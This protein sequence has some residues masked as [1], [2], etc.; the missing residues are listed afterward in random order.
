MSKNPGVLWPIEPHTVAKLDILRFYLDA[1]FPILSARAP[2]LLYIDG[3]AGPGRYL[4]G[5][6]GSPIVALNSI[7]D[8][9]SPLPCVVD[10]IFVEE[11]RDRFAY[12]RSELDQITLPDRIHVHPIHGRFDEWLLPILNQ[13][14]P[15]GRRSAPTFAFVDPFGWRGMPFAL[16]ER[17]LRNPSCEVFVNFMYEEINRF[18]GHPQQVEAWDELFGTNGWRDC[19]NLTR[20][21]ERFNCISELY[22]SQLL[23]RTN[24]QFSLSFEMRNVNKRTDYL[25]FFASQSRQGLLK[26]KEAMWRVDRSGRFVFSDAEAGP[27][28]LLFEL[29]PDFAQLRRQILSRLARSQVSIEEIERFVVEE[30][31]FLNTHYR[32]S[33]LRGMESENPP[34]IRVV[35]A[36]AGRRQGTFPPGTMIQFL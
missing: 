24:A 31:K 29:G 11:N 25:L 32:T 17:L 21:T 10:L 5:E 12:L 15:D 28:K 35:K 19:G 27:Q 8:R 20:P 6:P 33:I 3:F 22:R 4:G 36:P 34:K 14:E 18:L 2:R 1:W 16:I 9:S 30:T 23:S 7:L 26:M 13:F